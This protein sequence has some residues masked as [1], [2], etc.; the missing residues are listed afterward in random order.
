M[1]PLDQ[2]R[3]EQRRL[4]SEID[5]REQRINEKLKD[6]ETN[7]G[8]MTLNSILPFNTD[9]LEKASGIF[10]NINSMI[11]K[12]IPSSVGEEKREKIQSVLK[13]VE[14]AAAGLAYKYVTKFFK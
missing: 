7:F 13:T 6:L 1:K 10:S 12:I 3:E 8:K 11:L 9:Q 2:L 4:K 14:M 5:L